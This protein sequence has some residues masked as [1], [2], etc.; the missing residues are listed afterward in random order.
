MEGGES[1]LFNAKDSWPL[2]VS[3]FFPAPHQLGREVG[4]MGIWLSR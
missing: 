3:S 2:K 1:S 4:D